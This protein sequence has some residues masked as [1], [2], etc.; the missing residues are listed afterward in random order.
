MLGKKL[1]LT[2]NYNFGNLLYAS[3]KSDKKDGS[4][5]NNHSDPVY[6][7]QAFFKNKKSCD[8]GGG[9]NS[10]IVYGEDDR[11]LYLSERFYKKIDGTI[12]RDTE[13]YPP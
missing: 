11:A 12:I 7:I 10:Y 3:G 6:F 4:N 8:T 9:Y 13:D 2:G 1:D 5:R